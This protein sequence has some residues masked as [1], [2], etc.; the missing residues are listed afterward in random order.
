MK[1]K[2]VIY[3]DKNKKYRFRLKA[4]NGEVAMTS[5]QYDTESGCLNGIESVKRNAPI[6]I[7]EDTTI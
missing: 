1:P 4:C 3:K 5:E 2:F 7:I 6:A